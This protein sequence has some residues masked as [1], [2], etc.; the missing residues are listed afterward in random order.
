MLAVLKKIQLWRTIYSFLGNRNENK[1][2]DK[3]TF[4]STTFNSL[5]VFWQISNLKV[6]I[7]CFHSNY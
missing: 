4:C 3:L 5:P 6:C 1:P 2:N 7:Q